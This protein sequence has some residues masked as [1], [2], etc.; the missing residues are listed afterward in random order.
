MNSGVERVRQDDTRPR[1]RGPRS[2]H[3]VGRRRRSCAEHSTAVALAVVVSLSSAPSFAQTEERVGIPVGEANAYPAIRIDY[4]ANDNVFVQPDD[5]VSG[6]SVV[7]SPSVELVAD[8]RQLTLRGS[9]AGEFSQ[10][11]EN[12]LDHADHTLTLDVDAEVDKRRRPSA[13]V[14][15]R[16][17]HQEIGFDLTRGLA[18][19]LNEPVVFDQFDIG[20]RFRY[21]VVDARGNLEGGVIYSA[22]R[23]ANQERFTDGRDFTSLRPYGLFS[24]RL[25]GDTRAIAEVRYEAVA[26]SDE[27]TDRGEL[28][29]FGGVEFAATGRFRGE[30]RI[31]ATRARYDDEAREDVTLLAASADLS[32]LLREY[33]TLTLT[34][35]RELDDSAIQE[36]DDGTGEQAITDTIR[37][38]WLHEWSSRV[39]HEAFVER[40]SVTQLCPDR[41][42][43]TLE[44]GL[45]LNV[46]VRRWLSF[47][48]TAAAQSRNAVDCAGG[49]DEISLDYERRLFGAY[50]RVTL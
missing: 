41:D 37:F 19:G 28:S 26:R 44:G 20:A 34:F 31:G 24:Y 49:E 3:A 27:R 40:S 16:R 48:A 9:Y 13:F 32:Y 18:V 2:A 29:V 10:G 50:V 15:Y 8:R 4:L 14:S 43:T 6:S 30:A 35:D 36:L 22:R 39:S 33:A 42:T 47:G 1:E 21:G 38:G 5:A 11:S 17:D 25:S 46:E 23:Y 12:V 7:V 45:D